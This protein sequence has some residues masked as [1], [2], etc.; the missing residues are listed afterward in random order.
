M[1]GEK[2]MTDAAQLDTQLP[3]KTILKNNTIISDIKAIE[4]H[5]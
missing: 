1:Q 3:M 5:E 2:I 4:N